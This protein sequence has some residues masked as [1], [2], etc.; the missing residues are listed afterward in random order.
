MQRVIKRDG[1]E[2]EF[3][4]LK[5]VEAISKANQEILKSKQIGPRKIGQIANIVEEKCAAYKRAIKVED[6]NDL[7]EDELIFRNYNSL[8]RAFIKYRYNKELIRKSNTTDDSILSLINLSNEEL[9]QENANK[10]PV[11]TSTQRDYMAGEVSKDL[12]RRL[13]L[14]KDIV[15]AHDAGILHFHDTDYYA[16][17]IHNC[18]LINL[19]DM[20]QNGTVVSGTLIEKPHSFATACN[21]ATQ[22]VAQVASSQ[23]GGQSITLSHL[24]PFVNISALYHQ[25]SLAP[26]FDKTRQFILRGGGQ[27]ARP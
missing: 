17:K 22:I 21:I 14:S 10:N 19:E 24:A 27:T 6:I 11:I 26:K 7:I 13:L 5:I 16:Q 1:R 2:V 9:K 18:D 25:R 23:Y 20:L 15:S 12:T 4:K 3:D 8:V